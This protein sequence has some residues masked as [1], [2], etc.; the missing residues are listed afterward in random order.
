ML[1]SSLVNDAMSASGL[2]CGMRSQMTQ[3]ID[4]FGYAEKSESFVTKMRFSVLI[5]Q[6]ASRFSLPLVLRLHRIL[7]R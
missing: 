3:K 1:F 2:Y 6:Q 5:S 4:S 7:V